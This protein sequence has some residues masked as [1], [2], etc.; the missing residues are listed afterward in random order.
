MFSNA[1]SIW[2][3]LGSFGKSWYLGPSRKCSEWS[4]IGPGL[5]ACCDFSLKTGLRT[6]SVI[7]LLTATRLHPT[8]SLLTPPI[9]LKKPSVFLRL[10][11]PGFISLC[12]IS[13]RIGGRPPGH[14][15]YHIDGNQIP[16][17]IVCLHRNSQHETETL[18]W[19]DRQNRHRVIRG[20]YHHSHWFV[21]H[22]RTEAAKEQQLHWD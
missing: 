12:L 21:P 4:G 20:F 16:P 13:F 8:S 22:L 18:V 2:E 9:N 14:L 19:D 1:G 17:S 6:P 5:S 15:I 7:S 3:S 11:F 10:L